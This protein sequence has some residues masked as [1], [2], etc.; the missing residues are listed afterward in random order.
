MLPS[1]TQLI[2]A[3]AEAPAAQ[4]RPASAGMKLALLLV[5]IA[6]SLAAFLALDY[7]RSAGDSAPRQG[8]RQTGFLP[9][10][11]SGAPSRLEAQL[12]L[13]RALGPRHV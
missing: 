1:E 6:F 5:S 4:A 13:R 2:D 8:R 7:F 3:S 11:R 12:R 10:L 9:G